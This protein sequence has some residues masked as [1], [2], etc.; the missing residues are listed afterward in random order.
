MLDKAVGY[1]HIGLSVVVASYFL[2]SGLFKD[3]DKYFVIYFCLLNIS[4]VLFNDECLISYFHKIHT[5]G[6]Y[7]MGENKSVSDYDL[8]LGEEHSAVFVNLLLFMYLINMCVILYFAVNKMPSLAVILSYMM[9]IASLRLDVGPKWSKF[10]RSAHM[11]VN[12]L[13]V[14]FLLY[15]RK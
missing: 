14:A 11:L 12:G 6:S 4:W 13:V 10:I 5:D 1:V 15:K 7:K 3:L 2:W 8:V 9:Y